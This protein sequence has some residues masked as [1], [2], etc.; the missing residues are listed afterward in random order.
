VLC[1]LQVFN[2]NSLCGLQKVVCFFRGSRSLLWCMV[3]VIWFWLHSGIPSGFWELDVALGVRV[4][5]YKFVCVILSFPD[6]TYICFKLFLLIADKNNR[7]IFWKSTKTTLCFAFLSFFLCYSSWIFIIPS[8]F[9]KIFQKQFTPFLFKAI[10]S[11]KQVSPLCER[12]PVPTQRKEKIP[13]EIDR[14]RAWDWSQLGT[15]STSRNISCPPWG[16]ITS[17]LLSPLILEASHTTSG[18]FHFSNPSHKLSPS[19]IYSSIFIAF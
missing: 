12:N 3:F 9:S 10:Y 11:N 16:S 13:I 4:N 15:R 18:M 5:Q 2:I 6:L 14:A 17:W 7:L 8:K 1:V 19:F